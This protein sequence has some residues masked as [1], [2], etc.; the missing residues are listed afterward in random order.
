MRGQPQ[1]GLCCFI[2]T[3][4]QNQIPTWALRHFG[5]NNSRYFRRTKAR[6]KASSIDGFTVALP[7]IVEGTSSILVVKA[8]DM[9]E[10]LCRTFLEIWCFQTLGE[11]RV[12]ET[13]E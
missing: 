13:A 1:R 2:S 5:E 6:W 4:A 10:P 7:K 9:I 8:I 3:T 12:R 11:K